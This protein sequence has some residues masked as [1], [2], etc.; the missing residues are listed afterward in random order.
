MVA[1]PLLCLLAR[2][3]EFISG[4]DYMTG[5]RRPGLPGVWDL[6]AGPGADEVENGLI[7]AALIAGP[8]LA[9]AWAR[10]AGANWSWWQW[11]VLMVLASELFGGMA[12]NSL[13]PAK[14]WH[15]RAGQG[16]GTHYTFAALHIHPLL[17]S[18]AVPLAMPMRAA[19]IIYGLLLFGAGVMLASPDRLRGGLA[20]LYSLVAIA[21]CSIW[22]PLVSPVGWLAPALYLKVLVAYLVPPNG[23][24]CEIASTTP[25]GPWG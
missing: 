15:H 18:I 12:A 16:M 11:L 7:V 19:L 23:S 17:L 5:E 4:D 13:A 14:Q 9:I 3:D 1:D 2:A 24:R 20:V 25:T 6:I 8:G 21:L 22:L 10:A